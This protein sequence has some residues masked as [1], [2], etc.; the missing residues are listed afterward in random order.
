MVYFDEIL[1]STTTREQWV[2]ITRRVEAV[3]AA[4]PIVNGIITISSLHTTAAITVNENA[5]P[6]VGHD[7]F[8][9]LAALVPRQGNYRHSEG[10]SDSH[11]KASLIGLSAQVPLQKGRLVLGTWQSIYFCEFDGPRSRRVTVTVMGDRDQ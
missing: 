10:N 1:L 6:D 11:L 8:H 9:K 3:F 7:I 4:S 5:D 2:D